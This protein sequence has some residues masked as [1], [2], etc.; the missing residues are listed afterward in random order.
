VLD[1]CS[2]DTVWL[3]LLMFY[4]VILMAILQVFASCPKTLKRPW[5]KYCTGCVPFLLK[6]KALRCQCLLIECD[7]IMCKW[8]QCT[9]LLNCCVVYREWQME[10]S[11]QAAMLLHD[12]EVVFVLGTY[13]IVTQ[14]WTS[15]LNVPVSHTWLC[16]LS[17]L[18]CV[19]S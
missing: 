3:L 17:S 13:S 2:C 10:R 7:I 4:T 12:P 16:T 5:K 15:L 18:K 9:T 19:Y 1:L 6:C 8:C 11:F 14:T